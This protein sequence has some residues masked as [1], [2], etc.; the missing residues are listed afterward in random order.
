MHISFFLTALTHTAGE[1][2]SPLTL[3][4]CVQQLRPSSEDHSYFEKSKNCSWKYCNVS[5]GENIFCSAFLPHTGRNNVVMIKSTGCCH[6][7]SLVQAAL[8]FS[9]FN[10]DLDHWFLKP[11]NYIIRLPKLNRKMPVCCQKHTVTR[12]I[13]T[14]A[15]NVNNLI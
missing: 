12:E 5:P 15:F 13:N 7:D 4:C 14:N 9:I 10:Q 11:I 1:L 8:T 3:A 2:S 6:P